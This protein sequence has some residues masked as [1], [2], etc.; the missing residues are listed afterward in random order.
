MK[1]EAK[2]KASDS[3]SK[4]TQITGLITGV[5]IAYAITCI[6][7]IGCALA[8]THTSF[9]ESSIPLVV[10]I[11]CLISVFIAGFDASRASIKNGWLWGIIAGGIYVIILICLLTWITGEL[12]I[13][14]RKITLAVLSLAGG[15]VGGIIGINFKPKNR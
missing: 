3:E 15:G 10:T 8:L 14:V 12:V 1:S 11:T 7:F 2:S 9:P 4:N 13:D 6:S 5:L